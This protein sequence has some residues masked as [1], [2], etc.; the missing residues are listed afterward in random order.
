MHAQFTKALNEITKLDSWDIQATLGAV[1]Y[2][3]LQ[4]AI[5][6][7]VRLL[8]APP[9]E[10]SGIEDFTR[11]EQN[12]Q[13]PEIR[14][15][16]A[17]ILGYAEK[18]QEVLN[19][20]TTTEPFDFQ[21]V[22]DFMTSRPPQRATFE[23]EY[24]QRKKLGMR[25]G[26]PISKFVEMEYAQ[27]MQRHAR[28]VAIGETAVH[29]LSQMRGNDATAPDWFMEAIE[30]KIMQKLEQRW[31]RAEM[32]RTN[33]RITKEQRDLAE[34]NQALIVGVIEALGGKKP[35]F[36]SE[37]RASDDLEDSME[38]LERISDAQE[39]ARQ[40][41]ADAMRDPKKPGPVIPISLSAGSPAPSK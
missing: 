40:A 4:S 1:N 24:N 31:E 6:Q 5:N 14:E 27:A 22:L 35:D 17:P 13:K 30:A 9:E 21:H 11:W 29:V 18:A 19:E 39:A 26:I 16:V 12:M 7:A 15:A 28:L 34:A 41:K 32:R 36:T 20:Y 33:P 10:G 25:P 3:A 23:A 8:P 38:K 37:I 2:L